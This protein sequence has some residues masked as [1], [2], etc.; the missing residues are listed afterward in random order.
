[1]QSGICTGMRSPQRAQLKAAVQDH[2]HVQRRV[3]VRGDNLLRSVRGPVPR[4][5]QDADALTR[6]FAVRLNSAA[7]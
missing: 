5:V 2:L 1:M 7:Q 6:R 3:A 4:R